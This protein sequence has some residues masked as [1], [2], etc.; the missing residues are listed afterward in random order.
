M[1]PKILYDFIQVLKI[2]M[3]HP[4][5]DYYFSMHILFFIVCLLQDYKL[6][7]RNYYVQKINMINF[8]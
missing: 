6:N 7:C 3:K 5:K 4:T 1:N 2:K 8:L